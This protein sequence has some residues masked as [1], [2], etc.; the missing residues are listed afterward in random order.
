MCWI[1]KVEQVDLAPVK[2]GRIGATMIG[3]RDR[4]LD[5]SIPSDIVICTEW[6]TND[7]TGFTRTVRSSGYYQ[8]IEPDEG[9]VSVSIDD[10]YQ[11]SNLPKGEVIY[12]H[13]WTEP[14]L[15]VSRQR[16][17]RNKG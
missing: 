8:V 13:E 12:L 11:P 4:V 14:V 10:L 2:S 1:T 7:Q 15:R 16:K 3:R 6:F 9:R 5:P 17:P